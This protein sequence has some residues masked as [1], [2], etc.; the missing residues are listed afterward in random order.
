ML[1][2]TASN[3]SLTSDIPR[4]SSMHA[5]P[6]RV[7]SPALTRSR[8]QNTAGARYTSS[9]NVVSV[10]STIVAVKCAAVR[11]TRTN[12]SEF[13]SS[14]RSSFSASSI[15]SAPKTRSPLGSWTSSECRKIEP[16]RRP[17]HR[18]MRSRASP[19]AN[20]RRRAAR[21]AP[22]SRGRE[23]ARYDCGRAAP[24]PS[25]PRRDRARARRQESVSSAA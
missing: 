18:G 1:P 12:P 8:R 20:R 21:T 17:E 22:A 16:A 10:A 24:L 5:C 14:F 15:R 3:P 19:R 11:S 9:Q 23:H 13:S 6:V 4:R 2:K 25:S 7:T